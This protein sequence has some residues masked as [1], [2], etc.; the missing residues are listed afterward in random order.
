MI[1][2]ARK[3]PQ[4]ISMRASD[5]PNFGHVYVLEPLIL[6]GE[7]GSL[8]ASAGAHLSL[9][10]PGKPHGLPDSIPHRKKLYTKEKGKRRGGEGREASQKNQGVTI[11]DPCR[12]IPCLLAWFLFLLYFQRLI[13]SCQIGSSGSCLSKSVHKREWGKRREKTYGVQG[14]DLAKLGEK[15]A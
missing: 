1:H 12:R 5:W 2:R 13:F 11:K 9:W 7:W 10:P 3:S 14:C 8:M 15:E 4:P 6:S